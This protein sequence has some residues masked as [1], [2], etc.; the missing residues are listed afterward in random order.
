MLIRRVVRIGARRGLAKGDRLWLIITAVVAVARYLSREKK[1]TTRTETL[2]R[3]ET[4]VIKNA[5]APVGKWR[6]L[7]SNDSHK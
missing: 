1:V 7:R 4:L 2:K 6:A 5:P 3:G